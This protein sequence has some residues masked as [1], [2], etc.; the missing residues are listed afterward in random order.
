MPEATKQ[1]ILLVEDDDSI[2]AMY[3]FKLKAA[4]YEIRTAGNGR[5]GLEIAK[6]WLPDVILLDIRMPV[7]SGD[8]M[9]EILRKEKWGS[10]VR[11]IILTNISRSE[12]PSLLRF[13]NVDRYIVKAHTTP[14]EVVKVIEEVLAA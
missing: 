6:Q 8:K 2:R 7:M 12:A 13:L 10:S 9:L 3:A 11:V 5:E 1:K 14:G 4:D